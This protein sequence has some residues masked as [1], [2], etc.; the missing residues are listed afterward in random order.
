MEVGVELEYLP[1]YSPDHDP[2]KESFAELKAW[3]RKHSDLARGYI[4]R[5]EFEDFIVLAVEQF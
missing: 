5:G 3:M 2:M 4:E 1:P